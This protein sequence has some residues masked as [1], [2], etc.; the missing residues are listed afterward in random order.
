MRLDSL[1]APGA[2]RLRLLTGEDELDRRVT[3]VMT[4][5]LNDPSR[6]LRGGELVLTGT[7]VARAL[8]FVGRRR[9]R[10]EDGHVR[11]GRR[12]QCFG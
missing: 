6:Y 12:R 2:P 1:L 11:A 4:T 10:D 8:S 9:A 7:H 5:D 3:G